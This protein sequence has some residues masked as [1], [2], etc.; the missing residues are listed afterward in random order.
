MAKDVDET[1]R[2]IAE[3]QGSLNEEAAFEYVQG[4][5]DEHRYHRDV[6]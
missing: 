1:T 3:Q 4:L 5:R 6:Y 2:T